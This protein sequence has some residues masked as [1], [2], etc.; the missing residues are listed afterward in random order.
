MRPEDLEKG[1]LSNDDADMSVLT[2]L[3]QCVFPANS[4][5]VGRSLINE[6]YKRA[7]T[8][9]GKRLLATCVEWDPNQEYGVPSLLDHHTDGVSCS[10]LIP[11]V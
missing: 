9:E 1:L 10:I 3:G 2:P 11:F 5:L 4:V 7:K 8:N 6:W